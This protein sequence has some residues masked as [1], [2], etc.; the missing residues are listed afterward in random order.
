MKDGD[1]LVVTA[2]ASLFPNDDGLRALKKNAN[3]GKKTAEEH[4]LYRN[5][6]VFKTLVPG[7]R[8]NRDKN[9]ETWSAKNGEAMRT[10]LKLGATKLA[11]LLAMDL[12]RSSDEMPAKLPTKVGGDV[13]SMDGLRGRIIGMDADGETIRFENETMAFVVPSAIVREDQ[14]RARFFRNPYSF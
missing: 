5:F 2:K 11:A 14:Q 13:I 10:A 6:F 12:Q 3:S 1:L 9:I 7:E 8:K 4:A